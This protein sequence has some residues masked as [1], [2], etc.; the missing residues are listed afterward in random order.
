MNVFA[1]DENMIIS[2][3][4]STKVELEVFV[5]ERLFC[6]LERETRPLAEILLFVAQGYKKNAEDFEELLIR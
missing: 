4:L 6:L 2:S 1:D 5:A 3:M